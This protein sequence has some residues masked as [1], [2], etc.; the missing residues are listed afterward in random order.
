MGRAVFIALPFNKG[1]CGMSINYK[2][3]NMKNL[4]HLLVLG[5]VF[6]VI[7]AVIHMFVSPLLVLILPTVFTAPLTLTDTLLFLILI[8]Q[9]VKKI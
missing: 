2:D 8:T 7:I 5:L 4:G 9:M 1:G 6:T 3:W